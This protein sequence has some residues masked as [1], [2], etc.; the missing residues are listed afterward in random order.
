MI[1]T[2][3]ILLIGNRETAEDPEAYYGEYQAF[4]QQAA[5]SS[6]GSHEVRYTL[7]E[8]LIIS[9]GDGIFTIFDTRHGAGIEDYELVI[10][11][12]KGLRNYF[13]I[14][15][16]V[17][18]FANLHGVKIINDYSTFRDSSKLM[19]AVVF[20]ELNIPVAKTVFVT[21]ALLEE[22]APL[23]FEYPCIMKAVFGAHGNDN[24]LIKDI[25]EAREIAAKDSQLKFVMQRFVPND[26]D[27]RLL[28]TGDD[29]LT[30][31]REAVEGSHLNNTSQ[32]GSAQLV[33]TGEVPEKVLDDARR[34]T[35][36]LNMTFS[37][38]DVLAD[39]NTGD[40]YFLEVNS[41]PQLMSGA[42]IDKKI[43]A[44][45]KYLDTLSGK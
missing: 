2:M 11:R 7:F 31:G 19:Q 30:I 20:Y 6:E 3:K 14:V 34:V 22:K 10:I 41:Q 32:G 1:T 44:I 27:Y 18:T 25:A 43:I 26:R 36:H 16:A 17:S 28:V 39:K 35:K 9:V 42:Y 40:F 12:G 23:G 38:V 37:G 8:D 21:K 15:K 4:F 5:D 13:D 45:G 24:Y 29:V 33:A